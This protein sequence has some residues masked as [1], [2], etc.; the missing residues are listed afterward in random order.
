MLTSLVFDGHVRNIGNLNFSLYIT[1]TISI[2]LELP[3][4]LLAIVGLNMLGRRWSACLS[5]ALSSITM[6]IVAF[7]LGK[8]L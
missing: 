8:L 4:D 5:L 1:F 2:L 6:V 7:T 3:A